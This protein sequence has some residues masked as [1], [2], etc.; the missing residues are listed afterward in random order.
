MADAKKE[1]N[2][3]GGERKR[4]GKVEAQGTGNKQLG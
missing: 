2:A 4:R 1:G 3:K